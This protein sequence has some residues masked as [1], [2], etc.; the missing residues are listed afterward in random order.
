MKSMNRNLALV[1]NS[2]VSGSR[3][4]GKVDS[5][6]SQGSPADYM[7]SSITQIAVWSLG[8]EN[9]AEWVCTENI[10]QVYSSQITWNDYFPR[11]SS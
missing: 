3:K 5:E 9:M 6:E 10:I 4:A 1:K 8:W 11:I 7:T 2:L